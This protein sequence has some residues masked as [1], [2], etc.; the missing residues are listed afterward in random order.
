MGVVNNHA[1][2]VFSD[3]VLFLIL[4]Q[5]WLTALKLM[6]EGSRLLDLGR[7]ALV[8]VR[9]RGDGQLSADEEQARLLPVRKD[10]SAPSRRLFRL[11][12]TKPQRARGSGFGSEI[13]NDVSG[14]T[15][16]SALAP[17]CAGWARAWC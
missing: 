16:D 1:H 11:T 17:V 14:L 5:Q 12:P 3:G 9:A 2:S 7:E 8:P 4:K 6:D 15:W 10:F 13:V